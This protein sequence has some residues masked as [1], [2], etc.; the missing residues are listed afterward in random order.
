MS[1]VVDADH[2][3]L[4]DLLADPHQHENIFD[5]IEVR[6]RSC[7]CRRVLRHQHVCMCRAMDEAG[8]E[9]VAAYEK[10][11]PAPPS[12]PLCL[13]SLPTPSFCRRRA[14]SSAGAWTTGQQWLHMQSRAM[15][16]SIC[17]NAMQDAA[18]VWCSICPG[19]SR[20]EHCLGCVTR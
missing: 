4:F 15:G 10:A 5:A 19:L 1:A 14:L 13:C 20:P 8:A 12:F 9:A 18:T 16:M 3:V 7:A 11:L 17:I 2:C 6:V